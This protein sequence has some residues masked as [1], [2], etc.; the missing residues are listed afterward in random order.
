MNADEIQLESFRRLGPQGR[1]RAASEM[2]DETREIASEGVRHRHPDY[3]ASQVRLA[4]LRVSLGEALF[5]RAF[6]GVDVRP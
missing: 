4:V 2:S 1:V 3:D 6:P 5:G